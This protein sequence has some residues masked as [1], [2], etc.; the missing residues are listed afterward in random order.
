MTTTVS[1]RSDAGLENLQP[2]V[3]TILTIVRDCD[4][5]TQAVTRPPEAFKTG[6]QLQAISFEPSDNNRIHG[7]RARR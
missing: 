7:Q 6:Q 3:G 5:A 1:I 4:H 2:P